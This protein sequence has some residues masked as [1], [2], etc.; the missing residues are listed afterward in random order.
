MSEMLDIYAAEREARKYRDMAATEMLQSLGYEYSHEG[1]S[2]SHAANY[3]ECLCPLHDCPV[4]LS[5]HT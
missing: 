1:W 4:R 5:N 2:I 3:G